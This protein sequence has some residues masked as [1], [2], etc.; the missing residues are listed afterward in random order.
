MIESIAFTSLGTGVRVLTATPGTL[1]KA[2]MAVQEVL[3][4]ID[5]ACSRFRDDSELCKLNRS[6]RQG[7]VVSPLLLTAIQAA[8]RACRL[9]EGA[10]DPTVGKAMRLIGYDRDFSELP[11]DAAL[12]LRLEATPGCDAIIVD[13]RSRQVRLDGDVQV[14]LGATAK[15][16]A[17][18]LAAKAAWA[19]AESGVL[20]SLGGDIALG[21]TAPERGWPIMIAED[22]AAPLDAEGEVIALRTGAVATSSTTVRSWQQGGVLRHHI[23]DPKTGAPVDGP[24]RTVSV[25]AGNCVDANAAATAAIV[26][27]DQALPWLRRHG[28]AARLVAS[29]GEVVRAGNWPAPSAVEA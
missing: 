17:A 2:A 6:G 8:K 11:S 25:V 23:V 18:D 15:A 4:E 29:D 21:G 7:M 5:V 16:L 14:D 28:L 1:D 3:Q 9:T 27:G 13:A 26:K 19:A 22:H 12:P 24:W 10:V 20:V